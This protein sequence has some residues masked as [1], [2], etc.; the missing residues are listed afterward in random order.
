[1]NFLFLHP[2]FFFWMVPPVVLLFYFWQ[3][4]QPLESRWL[5]SEMIRKLRARELTMGLKGRNT[6]FL[7]A[8]LLLIGAMAQPVWLQRT[9]LKERSSD[10]LLAID[11]SQ[12][13]RGAWEETKS[14][15]IMLIDALEEETIGI[16]GYD[17]ELFRIAPLSTQRPLLSSLVRNLG[18]RGT[19]DAD[20][21]SVIA[22]LKKSGNL[23]GIGAVVFVSSGSEGEISDSSEVPVAT[24]GSASDIAP[25]LLHLQR[26]EEM[27][28]EKWHV[29]L[30]YY[31][32]G[33]SMILVLIAIS[34]MSQRRTVTV[35]LA[36]A[37]LLFPAQPAQADILDFRILNEAKRCYEQGD[38]RGSERLF[39]EYQ[40]RHDSPQVRYNRANALFRQGRFEEARYWYE[41]V[42]TTDPVLR[43]RTRKNL[44][45]TME[46]MKG[47]DLRVEDAQRT[48]VRKE[49]E[50][51]P[52]L[53]EQMESGKG[54]TRLFVIPQR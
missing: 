43:E 24:V 14:T 9:P 33:L 28:R 17:R 38:Y 11:M 21:A 13:D 37:V 40:S 48:E 3:T 41:R 39:A 12:N 26:W 45:L 23:D 54:N 47:A 8:A 36:A 10:L 25:L 4:Q 42:F 19:G 51:R 46:R 20:R 52:W 35:A 32:L 5:D 44:K 34:S 31:P 1:M 7:A 30:F 2:E 6:L 22:R 16:V 18:F 50:T 27:K 53:L 49:K 29:P 15:T